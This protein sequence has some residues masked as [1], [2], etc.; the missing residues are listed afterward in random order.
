MFRRTLRSC[1]IRSATRRPDRRRKKAL[2]LELLESRQ[3]LTTMTVD[4][5][6]DELDGSIV[7]GDTS[8]RDAI[9]VANATP[10]TDTI[11]FDGGLAGG[12]LTLTIGEML[13]TDSVTINGL[14]AD[15]MTIDGGGQS[16]IS[17]STM[18]LV[19]KPTSRSRM[20]R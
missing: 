17:F 6:V 19:T 3:L 16:R 14:G 20:L 18:A 10:G 13:I 4:T 9:A 7:D 11:N 5:F 2:S 15:Q 8:L 12:T 1:S